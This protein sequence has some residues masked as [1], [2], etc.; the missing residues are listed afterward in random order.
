VGSGLTYTIGN[1]GGAS[2]VTLNIS[3]I[4]AHN[5]EVND[6]GHNHAAAGQNQ[7]EGSSGGNSNFIQPDGLSGTNTTGITIKNTGESGAHENK[8]P[9][10]ALAFIMRIS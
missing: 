7:K 10:Y 9:Y 5:H 8:P 3:E 4:P 6:P 1:T 2:T